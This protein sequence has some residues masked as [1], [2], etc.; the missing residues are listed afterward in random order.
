MLSQL[1]RSCSEVAHEQLKP[2][3][4]SKFGN[5]KMAAILNTILALFEHEIYF[6][7]MELI[8]SHGTRVSKILMNA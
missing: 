1:F 6:R 8:Y 4:N 7:Y 2:F 3:F 5:M